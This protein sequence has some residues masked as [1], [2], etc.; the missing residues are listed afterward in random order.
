MSFKKMVFVL[1]ALAFAFGC[2]I[3]PTKTVEPAKTSFKIKPQAP[4]NLTVPN[5]DTDNSGLTVKWENEDDIDGYFLFYQTGDDY[6]KGEQPNAVNLPK[7]VKEWTFSNL[8][9]A[10]RYVFY[11][12]SYKVIAGEV[13]FSDTSDI[14]ESATKPA[15][16]MT[17][18]MTGKNSATLYFST[19]ERRSVL[20]VGEY[21]YKPVFEVYSD[22]ENL[23][24][25]NNNTQNT[26]D[27]NGGAEEEQ[28][29]PNESARVASSNFRANEFHTNEFH[30]MISESVNGVQLFKV[31]QTEDEIVQVDYLAPNESVYVTFN[32]YVEKNGDYVSVEAAAPETT[33]D[34]PADM[35]PRPVQS[36]SFDDSVKG[37]I[38]ITFT[39]SP[40]NNGILAE[41]EKEGDRVSQ[42]FSID[43]RI[44]GTDEW[45]NIISEKE[46]AD[47][48]FKE[49]ATEGEPS[50][51][52]EDDSVS[53]NT[54]YDYRITPFY[55]V[56]KEKAGAISYISYKC[57]ESYV[58][59]S[60]YCL[61]K[62]DKVSASLYKENKL[63]PDY[64]AS[65]SA[66]I[67]YSIDGMFADIYIIDANGD[68]ATTTLVEGNIPFVAI[69]ENDP[70]AKDFKGVV[71]HTYDFTLDDD[72]D[73]IRQEYYYQIV[74]KKGESDTSDVNDDSLDAIITY[75]SPVTTTP[76]IDP[77]DFVSEVSLSDI[78][79]NA[80]KIKLTATLIDEDKLT[81]TDVSIDP[82]K[83]IIYIKRGTSPQSMSQIKRMTFVEFKNAGAS[84]TDNFD[85]VDSDAIDGRSFYY[86]VR[87]V[88]EDETSPYNS[89]Y[90]FVNSDAATTLASPEKAVA[91]DGTDADAINISFT[92]VEGA[93]GYAIKYRLSADTTA[94]YIDVEDEYITIDA[95]NGSAKFTKEANT[96]EAGK[97]YSFRIYAKDS[98]GDLTK[99]YAECEGS[100]FGLYNFNV[101]ATQDKYNDRIVVKW[102]E[103]SNAIRY[104]INVYSD[105]ALTNDIFPAP[106]KKGRS[107]RE[108]ILDSSD[109]NPAAF[110]DG[111]PLN[112]D[113]WFVVKPVVNGVTIDNNLLSPAKGTWIKPPK[114]IKATKG[115]YG[116]SIK[117]TWDSVDVAKGYFVYRRDEGLTAWTQL[118][119]VLSNAA[120]EYYDES[121]MINRRYEYSISSVTA[122][123]EESLV[124]N[125][126]ETSDAK[127]NNVGFLLSPPDIVLPEES[128]D[129]IY[130]ITIKKPML[131]TGLCLNIDGDIKNFYL[132]N[133]NEWDSH[134]Y[135]DTTVSFNEDSNIIIKTKRPILKNVATSGNIQYI[136]ICAIYNGQNSAP[137]T[138]SIKAGSYYDIE[139]V[140]ILHNVLKRVISKANDHF[141]GDWW[142][143]DGLQIYNPDS[144]FYAQ[145]EYSTTKIVFTYTNTSRKGTGYIKFTNYVDPATKTTFN[146]DNIVAGPDSSYE[147]G[148]GGT[149]D[150][151]YLGLC[152]GGSKVGALFDDKRGG[153]V[154]M[155]MGSTLGT[156]TIEFG[157]IKTN[158]TDGKY[159]VKYKNKTTEVLVTDLPENLR[160]IT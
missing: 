44:S 58:L 13:T 124:Q 151:L 35:Y 131:Y 47:S 140:S 25:L 9:E 136:S 84:F 62:A 105:E 80:G 27:D 14:K 86:Q 48:I 16:S 112:H 82:E 147:L 128:E 121:A 148:Y 106:I 41:D 55:M 137:C 126:F 98:A 11:A 69:D 45:K 67:P 29:E 104:E 23:F 10:E 54:A 143:G 117:V 159:K 50:R 123:P 52:F 157:D 156:A 18:V 87:A 155:D 91:S 150:L 34:N 145:T 12:K 36:A 93:A 46:N 70:N 96:T 81:A 15:L 139:I 103:V 149:Q 89:Q 30:P 1:V 39:P 75:T 85:G 26:E 76:T 132:K 153:T 99:T 83:L 24:G 114:N 57:D 60:A 37:S 65:I 97:K 64:S 135:E 107:E 73:T 111:Y 134:S 77:I 146:S 120:C 102:S 61:Q 119:Y 141:N 100:L 116:N 122:K 154:T 8:D 144:T 130:T 7:D 142:N 51:R 19:S 133:E 127:F 56:K 101:E 108:F 4:K 28:E 20:N 152:E 79:E 40:I 125:F 5:I 90:S 42:V 88:V 38:R 21:I 17:T 109:L 66:Y 160:A 31:L 33:I 49:E 63:V 78:S 3:V 115:D 59:E 158:G 74:V 72:T 118:S 32:M 53:L 6:I 92:H 113:F 94:E 22:K 68:S 95:E 43:R 110:D 71:K 2:K 129:K 138:V